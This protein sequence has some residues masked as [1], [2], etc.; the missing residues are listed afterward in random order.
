MPQWMTATQRD[1]AF[2]LLA[3]GWS[4]GKVARELG[5]T[6]SAISKHRLRGVRLSEDKAVMG[7]MGKGGRKKLLSQEQNR[8]LKRKVEENQILNVVFL[9]QILG[10]IGRK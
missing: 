10:L 4:Q 6:K 8:W 3:A 9:A 1:K 5:V 2:G 7:D